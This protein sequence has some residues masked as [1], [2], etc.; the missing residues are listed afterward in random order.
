MSAEGMWGNQ[1][2]MVGKIAKGE[3]LLCIWRV[4]ECRHERGEKKEIWEPLY[5]HIVLSGKLFLSSRVHVTTKCKRVSFF[6]FSSAVTRKVQKDRICKITQRH[7][8]G[9]RARLCTMK[10]RRTEQPWRTKKKGVT[11]FFFSE[12]IVSWF[13]FFFPSWRMLAL[14]LLIGFNRCRFDLTVAYTLRPLPP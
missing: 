12:A 1:N 4:A 13:V 3:N 8:F 2:K 5:F 11:I 10:S 6:F 14:L 7:T 9:S